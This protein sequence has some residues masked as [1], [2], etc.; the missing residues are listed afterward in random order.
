MDKLKA[1]VIDAGSWVEIHRIVLV[2]GERAPQCPSDTQ[3][4][5]LEM[6][7]EGFLTTSVTVGEA[8]EVVTVASR[9]LLGTLTQVNPGYTHAFGPPIPEL[10]SIGGE[11]RAI[12]RGG[13]CGWP[14]TPRGGKTW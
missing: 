8:A 5:T 3:H 6:C 4:A 14:V 2:P 13:T 12:L 10:L 1:N 7:I 11:V 9:R